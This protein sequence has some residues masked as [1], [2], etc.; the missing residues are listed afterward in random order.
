MSSS[1]L[2]RIALLLCLAALPAAAQVN[3]TYVIA[4]AANVPGAFGTRWMTQIS[5]M[6]PQFDRDLRVSVTYLPTNGGRGIEKAVDIPANAVA[7]SDNILDDL[8]DV[9]GTGSLLVAVFPEDN[10]G[11]PDTVLDRSILVTSNTYNNAD[12]GTY[13]QTIPGVWTGL[14]DVD[15]DGIFSIAHG[16]RNIASAGWRTNIG[17]V[18]LGRCS[19]RVLVSVYD[20]D[21]RRILNEAPLVVPPLGHIQ[22]ALPV[23]VD[24]GSVEFSVQ[25]PCSN[26]Q[27]RFAVVFPYV[28]TIDQLSGDPTYQ[29]P[30]LLASPNILYAAKKQQL[31]PTTLGR[32]IDTSVARGVRDTASRLGAAMLQRDGKGYRISA[33]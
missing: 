22:D 12:G 11:V 33:Q 10:P 26:D 18:N 20:Y 2:L 8:F 15:T 30:T 25:D 24:R 21:G 16:V 29:T 7:Y 32:K 13:G 14:F 17:A 3:D 9:V 27:E 5:L 19:V 6:N 31:D 23:Q 1:R 4:A 28:S